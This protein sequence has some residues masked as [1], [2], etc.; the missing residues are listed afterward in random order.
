MPTADISDT[1]VYLVKTSETETGNLY[2]EYIHVNGNWEK[3][4]TQTVDLSDYYQK[5]ET[6]TLL[7]K[8]AEKVHSH[9]AAD[10]TDYVPYDDTEV[11]G[12]ISAESEARTEADAK[13]VGYQ[14]VQGNTLYMYTDDSK[15]VLLA[16]LELPTAPVQDVQVAGTS[17][18]SDGVANVPI[19]SSDKA[20]VIY[21]NTDK[22]NIGISASG[23]PYIANRNLNYYNNSMGVNHAI[24]KGIL[25][26]IK[27]AYVDDILCSTNESQALTTQQKINARNRIGVQH[28][29]LIETIVVDNETTAE[30]S[31]YAEPNGTPY[32]FA[33]LYVLWSIPAAK[34][35]S[36]IGTQFVFAESGTVSQT[37]GSAISTSARYSGVYW[38]RVK[39][40][41]YINGTTDGYVYKGLF[42]N[43]PFNTVENDLV[44]GFV[45]S[46]VSSGVYFPKGTT[47]YIYGIR[48]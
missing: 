1:T 29:R 46:T 37:L 33:E 39:Y 35:T 44:N 16:T 48:A 18:V 12:L 25:E 38:D 43:Y 15:A 3:L 10:I 7:E 30:I 26:N 31:R 8:K 4:G 5:E 27:Q 20:G 41:R 11:R 42:V 19:S 14:E 24:S 2:T 47:I 13:K 22:Y 28:E 23:H 32:E 45:I 36:N 34:A 40:G 21:S 17:V 9:V 6:D